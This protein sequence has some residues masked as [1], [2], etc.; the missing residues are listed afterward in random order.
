MSGAELFARLATIRARQAPEIDRLT[1]RAEK[2]ERERDEAME[3]VRVLEQRPNTDAYLAACRALNW[4]NEQ[5]KMMGGE[6]LALG[7]DAPHYPPDDFDW[8]QALQGREGRN[9]Q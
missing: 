7:G 6:P 3:R 2:A 8:R 1:A 4:R 5:I 9:K